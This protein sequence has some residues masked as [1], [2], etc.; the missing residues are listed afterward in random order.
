[1]AKIYRDNLV[2]PIWEGTVSVMAEDVVRVLCDERLGGGDVVGVFGAWVR[3]VLGRCA[4]DFEQ[5][6]QGVRRRLDE[7]EGLVRGKQKDELLYHGREILEH[8]EVVTE[9]ALLLFDASV[10]PGLV[11]RE[12]AMRWVGEWCGIG[13]GGKEVSW[14]DR[15]AVDRA[16]FLG[17]GEGGRLE[18]L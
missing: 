6:V 18:R 8:L 11:A 2:N 17:E 3:G 13:R 5:V 7:L 12:M 15:V 14:E 1:M 4:A 16:I 10:H 9:A